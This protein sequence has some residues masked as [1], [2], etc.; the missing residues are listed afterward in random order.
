M[1]LVYFDADLSLNDKQVSCARNSIAKMKKR[2]HDTQFILILEPP[3]NE[4][5]EMEEWQIKVHEL[6]N[7]KE[8]LEFPTMKMI[9]AE[10]K[11]KEVLPT[12]ED[13]EDALLN[14]MK[15]SGSQEQLWERMKRKELKKRLGTDCKGFGADPKGEVLR[16]ID[17][18]TGSDTT[19]GT[20]RTLVRK[21]H[22]KG[23][24][25][26]T[27]SVPSWISP[28]QYDKTDAYTSRAEKNKSYQ[29]AFKVIPRDKQI[30]SD[31]L[32]GSTSETYFRSQHRDLKSRNEK[33]FLHNTVGNGNSYIDDSKSYFESHKMSN[34]TPSEF[35]LDPEEAAIRKNKRNVRL[36]D[37]K[38]D[39]RNNGGFDS[40]TKLNTLVAAINKRANRKKHKIKDYSL[41]ALSSLESFNREDCMDEAF[42][43][44]DDFIPRND[45]PIGNKSILGLPK[46]NLRA[47]D[48]TFSVGRNSVCSVK[49]P[50]DDAA[51]IGRNSLSAVKL[52]PGLLSPQPRNV[53]SSDHSILRKE[54]KKYSFLRK[55]DKQDKEGGYKSVISKSSSSRGPLFSRESTKVVQRVYF[56]MPKPLHNKPSTSP[57][58]ERIKQVDLSSQSIDFDL[59]AFDLGED[60][61]SASRLISQSPLRADLRPLLKEWHSENN[62]YSPGLHKSFKQKAPFIPNPLVSS[63]ANSI[64][65][66]TSRL[67]RKA[68][69]FSP[70]TNSNRGLVNDLS[71][72]TVDLNGILLPKESMENA[73]S[74]QLFTS[75]DEFSGLIKDNELEDHAKRELERAFS[76]GKIIIY[77]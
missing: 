13:N 58:P 17:N 3:E 37:R 51:S 49:K 54:K 47:N 34:E 59:D 5:A 50:N 35:V 42:I 40:S 63:L 32:R 57:L 46:K 61:V 18:Y 33:S 66:E 24:F 11:E 1:E 64:A 41:G 75:N 9:L 10:Q 60:T 73:I 23:P 4:P 29:T 25:A 16:I 15:L 19:C 28:G 36:N 21:S 74:S 27:S 14:E 22:I 20:S 6:I 71:L 12:T 45:Q 44:E 62:L 31:P 39:V 68:A 7:R 43:P 72:S 76:D 26:I 8:K 70:M 38:T 67:D 56:P 48:D 77:N 53:S 69:T 55:N 2:I 52:Q 30:I 65:L